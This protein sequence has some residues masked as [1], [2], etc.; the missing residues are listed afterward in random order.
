MFKFSTTI[1]GQAREVECEPGASL[2]EVLRAYGYKSV[3]Q[4]CD[5]EGTCG[6][7]TV[8][9]DGQPVLSC[10]T[11]APK[12]AGREVVTVEALGTP[13]KPHP[14]QRAFVDAGAIQCGFCTPGMILSTKALLDRVNN[15]TDAQISEAL[16]GN[17]C[18][19]TGY[20]KI[21]DAVRMAAAA[22]RKEA[23]DE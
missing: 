6:A 15:P 10:I 2:H 5:N 21:K 17:L 18:R 3:K 20:V 16:S 13:A 1:N 19:C 23:G 11:P 4:G 9:L 8:L 14:I 12:A 22:V 7:C